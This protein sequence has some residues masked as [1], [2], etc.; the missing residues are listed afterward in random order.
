MVGNQAY[1]HVV[2][3]PGGTSLLFS[4]VFEAI[5]REAQWCNWLPGVLQE[6]ALLLRPCALRFLRVHEAIRA[7]VPICPRDTIHY[8]L[9]PA[10]SPPHF[11]IVIVVKISFPPLVQIGA[12][13]C[14]EQ[15]GRFGLL[16]QLGLADQCT[17]DG[18][19]PCLCYKNGIPFSDH[20]VSVNHA[21]FVS[22]YKGRSYTREDE[23]AVLISDTESM[24]AG[25]PRNA[26]HTVGCNGHGV[27][28]TAGSGSIAVTGPV[29]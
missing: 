9:I 7:E 8:A 29:H 24:T 22:C 12:V 4:T 2:Y 18:D 21:D 5:G 11:P 25:P 3:V 13:Y 10:M 14:S 28:G 6:S 17:F 26:G 1:R 15:I 23:E 16:L 27:P 19:E 20:P